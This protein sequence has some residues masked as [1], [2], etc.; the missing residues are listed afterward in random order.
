L[1]LFCALL[2]ALCLGVTGCGAVKPH[3][4]VDVNYGNDGTVTAGTGL[5]IGT[6]ATVVATGGYNV[7]TGAW[8]AG[9]SIVFKTIPPLET[10][11]ALARAH[12]QAT[13]RTD[14]VYEYTLLNFDRRNVTHLEAIEAALKAGATLKGI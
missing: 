1:I 11:T 4:N 7:A 10:Q 14:A 5:D 3:G 2:S 9:I 12:A 13:A 8:T 6:N